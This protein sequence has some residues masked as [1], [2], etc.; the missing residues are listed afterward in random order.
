MIRSLDYSYYIFFFVY[1]N[2]LKITN[3]IEKKNIKIL[4]ETNN[5]FVLF[6]IGI[7]LHKLEELNFIFL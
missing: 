3:F 4:E 2:T 1:K 5:N 7:D 6:F